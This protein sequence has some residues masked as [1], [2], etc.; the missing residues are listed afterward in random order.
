MTLWT[1]LWSCFIELIS[2]FV[3]RMGVLVYTVLPDRQQTLLILQD[4]LRYAGIVERA[5]KCI[6]HASRRILHAAL[7]VK[8]VTLPFL[9]KVCL[10]FVIQ[11]FM[12]SVT[13]V[14]P[15]RSEVPV[16]NGRD[17]LSGDKGEYVAQDPRRTTH[18]KG[19]RH[20]I[21]AQGGKEMQHPAAVPLPSPPQQ[22]TFENLAGPRV[23]K[24]KPVA[25]PNRSEVPTENGTDGLSGDTGK[26]DPQR[27]HDKRVFDVIRDQGGEKDQHF[28][29]DPLSRQGSDELQPGTRVKT[30]SDVAVLNASASQTKPRHDRS[31]DQQGTVESCPL[32]WCPGLGHYKAPECAGTAAILSSE[33]VRHALSHEFGQTRNATYLRIFKENPCILPQECA[34]AA[35]LYCLHAMEAVSQ[36]EM[37]HDACLK[38][39]K[40]DL[41]E[42]LPVRSR[43][44]YLTLNWVREL[45]ACYM[46]RCNFLEGTAQT[47]ALLDYQERINRLMQELDEQSPEANEA[48]HRPPKRLMKEPDEQ[49][50]EGNEAHHRPPK[51]LMVEPDEQLTEANHSA[52]KR[53]K[54]TTS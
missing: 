38:I 28:D 20:G 40:L 2:A 11:R 34:M 18:E 23:P 27:A 43:K 8:N 15:K 13:T 7:T 29:V 53:H 10:W 51:R 39:A 45:T 21:G 17:G 22:V 42:P 47:F 25:P 16:E 12:K 54:S 5:V 49:S 41:G 36:E 4:L 1:W 26:Y 6:L 44:L 31:P 33:Y 46:Q 48:D 32:P 52:P 19:T 30:C 37:T 35:A 24:Q 14:Q 9:K 3:W 50:T